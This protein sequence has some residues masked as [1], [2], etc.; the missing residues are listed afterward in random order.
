L[1]LPRLSHAQQNKLVLSQP[2]TL[3]IK[4]GTDA[5]ATLKLTALP[6]FHVNS[7]KP[8]QDYLIPLS[9]T[10]T[11]GPL[12]PKSTTYPTPEEIQLGPDTLTVFTGTFD[13]KT[14]FIAPANAPAGQTVMTGKLRY[15]ACNDRMCF[16]PATIDVHLPIV[17]E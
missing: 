17:L 3:T 11:E 2:D 15:Q 8:K 5:V 12:K 7:D 14:D 4:R 10:W 1:F 6:G 16:R 9:I 13:V